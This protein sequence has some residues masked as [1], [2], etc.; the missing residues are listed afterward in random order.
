MLIMCSISK[1]LA[2]ILSVAIVSLCLITVQ[3]ANAQST[4]KPSVP[5]FTAK[6]IFSPPENQSVNKTIELSI[7]N[8]PSVLAYNVRMR[9]NDGDWRLLYPN[10]NSV[11][12]QS[13]GEYTILSYSSGYLGVEYQYNLGYTSQNLSAGDKVDFQVQA[14]IGSIQRVF[15]PNFTSQLDMYP[16]VFIG[17]SSGWSNTQT[18]RIPDGLSSPNS[19]LSPTPSVH[20]LSWLI[21][22]PLLVATFT[23]AVVG[24]FRKHNRNEIPVITLS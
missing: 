9:I 19:T 3:P 17:E 22:L 18:I 7:K 24:L 13:D 5:E 16:Y 11:P 8:Q 12:I 15:N 1:S 21:I 20:E 4:P 2:L 10:N 6:P 14:M 23:Y